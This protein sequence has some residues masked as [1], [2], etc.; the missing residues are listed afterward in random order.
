M[1]VLIIKFRNI[2]DV[3]LSTPLI[4]DL[5][6]HYPSSI[7][8]FALNKG[9]EDMVLNN[10]SINKVIIYDRSR[11]KQLGIFSRLKEEV[12]LI[13]NVYQQKYDIVINLTEGDR[14]A[15]LALFSKAQIKLGF[16]VRKG[17][18]SKINIFDKLGDDKLWQH[19]VEKD[20]QFIELLGKDIKQK[21]VSIYWPSD[22]ER[23]VDNMLKKENI[24]NFIHLHP[25]SRW[26][27]KC[28]DDNRMAKIIDFLQIEKK[29]K[30][31]I[32]VAPIDKETDRVKKILSLCKSKPIDLSGKLT[33][34]HVACLSAKSKMFFGVDS[35]PMHMAAVSVPVL[36]IFGASFPAKWGPWNNSPN[37]KYFF[38]KDG[39]Q[40]NG[41]HT[42]ISNM[43]N[44][45]YY[46]NGIKKSRGMSLIDYKSVK[47]AL[48]SILDM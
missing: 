45:I 7:I 24:S 33:L 5:K 19:T 27:F 35:A 1:K 13:N 17:F 34:K 22:V 29:I 6:Y 37:R 31:V 39:I 3:L 18:L 36:S 14:G 16:P 12:G 32:T 21:K 41:K 28:W 46:E 43:T 48:S 44:E 9:C 4:S 40:F 47:D 8:D 42:I 25:V 38:D 2:G 30:V 26:M 11:I 10:P 15:I 20:L 23:E